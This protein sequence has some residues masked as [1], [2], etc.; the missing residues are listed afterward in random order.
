MAERLEHLDAGERD[1]LA[2]ALPALEHLIAKTPEGA[3]T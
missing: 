2:A 3:A 1:A